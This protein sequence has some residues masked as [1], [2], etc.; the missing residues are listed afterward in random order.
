[1]NLVLPL[2]TLIILLIACSLS[3]WSHPAY[4][5]QHVPVRKQVKAGKAY[6][7]CSSRVAYSA[8]NNRYVRAGAGNLIKISKQTL[9]YNVDTVY[10]RGCKL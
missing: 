9:L 10:L 6:G 4:A 7:L 3:G 5:A 1:M 8:V 2:P